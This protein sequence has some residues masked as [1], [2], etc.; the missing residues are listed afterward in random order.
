MQ[1]MQPMQ[2]QLDVRVKP[3]L[4]LQGSGEGFRQ[5][6]LPTSAGQSNQRSA[7]SS[8]REAE[9]NLLRAAMQ[10]AAAA[11]AAA[12]AK[13]SGAATSTTAAAAAAPSAAGSTLA[14]FSMP[15]QQGQLNKGV[16]TAEDMMCC[17]AD[18]PCISAAGMLGT[19]LGGINLGQ[20]WQQQQQPCS[21]WPAEQ[22]LLPTQQQQHLMPGCS[23]NSTAAGA[24]AGTAEVPLKAD[25]A[26]A[27]A[28]AD[29][30]GSADPGGFP[31]PENDMF[32]A[33]SGADED[34]SELFD[35]LLEGTEQ[36]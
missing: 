24:G 5:G 19:D 36:Q 22:L 30:Y 15:L 10:A 7:P 16:S 32:R 3:D 2:G 34:F 1:L 18:S 27:A 28:A 33:M 20:G 12:G 14:P 25:A 29:G 11:A 35:L 31:E 21:S 26:A 9:M 23:S 17:A 13:A 8:S 6:V 4:H